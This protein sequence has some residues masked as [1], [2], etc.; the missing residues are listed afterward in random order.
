MWDILGLVGLAFAVGGLFWV[1]TRI[2]GGDDLRVDNTGDSVNEPDSWYP[3]VSE[4]A[5]TGG[6]D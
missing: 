1:A 4:T 5:P 6:A 2:F 3:G